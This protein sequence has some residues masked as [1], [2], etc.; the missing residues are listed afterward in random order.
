M[1]DIEQDNVDGPAS[2]PPIKSLSIEELGTRQRKLQ[3]EIEEKESLMFDLES[4]IAGLN[5]EIEDLSF[6][7][8]EVS[9]AIE[10]AK[11]LVYKKE[12]TSF[13]NDEKIKV[14]GAVFDCAERLLNGDNISLEGFFGLKQQMRNY[15]Y[16]HAV[17]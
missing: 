3:A 5:E 1:N 13:L 15:G 10:D 11:I 9:S 2:Q 17:V 4:Q 7:L 14:S 16:N 6:E 12:L 8:G